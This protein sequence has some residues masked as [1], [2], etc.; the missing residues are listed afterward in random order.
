MSD[1]TRKDLER[2]KG[3]HHPDCMHRSGALPEGFPCPCLDLW[4]L[5]ALA[6][7]LAAGLIASQSAIA[8]EAA[9]SGEYLS[10]LERARRLLK[11]GE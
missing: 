1:I 7:E 9:L 6:E 5:I 11:E 4:R 8:D 2:F 3:Q 10:A